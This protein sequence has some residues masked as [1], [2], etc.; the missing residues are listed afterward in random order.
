MKVLHINAVYGIGSTGVIVEDI[1]KLS[2]KSGIDSY[3]AYSS[4]NNNSNDVINGY[5]I[6]K[7][8]DKK[9]HAL[10]SRINGKQGYFSNDATKE[11]IKH[12]NEIKPD[13]VHLHNLH[14]NYIYLNKLLEYLASVDISTVVT[15]HDCWFYTGGCFH[16]T[17]ARCD[18]W[19][20]ECGACPKK[21][22][23]TPAYLCDKSSKIL[24]DRKKYFSAI[25]DLTVV[26]VSNWITNEAKRTFFNEKRALPIYNGVDFDLFHPVQ[27]DLRKKLGIED[28]FVL[29]GNAERWLIPDNKKDYDY[30]VANLPKECVL[31]LFGCTAEQ[32]NALP[33]NVIGLTYVY[34]KQEMCKIYS[35]ADVHVNCSKEES[36]SLVNIEA[37]GCG[38]PTVTYKNTGA[39]ETVDNVSS[40]CVE[41][42]SVDKLLEKVMEI[43]ANGKQAYS[44]GC[45]EF[46]KSKFDKIENYQKYIDLYKRI[47]SDKRN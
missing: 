43:K 11:L 30:F 4:T 10:L 9:I 20:K 29:V 28:K 40:F 44:K 39:Q 32:I 27:S 2:M 17:N 3:V 36:L 24:K 31:V 6:G 38:T 19:L 33:Q 16:Y 34:D 14:S 21:K 45:R 13:I 25:N 46:V 42:E 22:Q 15:L 35:M 23:D 26:G 18:K 47:F 8:L 7:T 1:H 5:K 37:Q 41:N 12:I